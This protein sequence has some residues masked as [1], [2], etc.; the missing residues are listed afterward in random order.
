MKQFVSTVLAE[1]EDIWNGI[2]Q[3]EGVTYEEPT[4]T[5]VHG[6]IR[7]AC[8]FASSASG[9]FY[10]PGDRKVYL[11]T[12]FFEQLDQPVRRFGRFRA[13]LCDRA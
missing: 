9:P 10:C 6:Q 2:F 5:H 13:G 4:L 7:S 12:S 1:T 3:A 8:G 11:D